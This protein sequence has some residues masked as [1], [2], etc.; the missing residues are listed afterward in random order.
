M[1]RTTA[2]NRLLAFNPTPTFSDSFGYA[3]NY[4][5]L[6]NCDSAT[7]WTKVYDASSTELNTTTFKEG[8][9][10]VQVNY[11]DSTHRA[12]ATKTITAVD[13]SGMTKI[14]FWFYNPAPTSATRIDF[15]VG[16]FGNYREYRYTGEIY[17][18]WTYCEWDIASP[19]ATSGSPNMSAVTYLLV[20]LNYSAGDANTLFVIDDIWAYKSP[21]VT[22][23]V[24]TYPNN[25]HLYGVAGINAAN[26]ALYVGHISREGSG[27]HGRVVYRT[28]TPTNF[29]ASVDIRKICDDDSCGWV[30]FGCD[31]LDGAN[32][33]EAFITTTY[34][35]AGI[36]QIIEG[37]GTYEQIDFT[38][39]T[40]RQYHLDLYVEGQDATF[41]IDGSL[42]ARYTMPTTRTV[43]G[44]V[45]ES[46]AGNYTDNPGKTTTIEFQ[47]F[48]LYSTEGRAAATRSSITQ[49]RTAA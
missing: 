43:G 18:G 28:S 38:F 41:Y 1:A 44:I 49:A 24:W 15:R 30:R 6:D 7:G 25:S 27:N 4:K 9:G 29:H 37:T 19:Y 40:G 14:G 13:I 21:N 26:G 12:A 2:T 39:T 17:T 32:Y 34:S 23:G 48:K 20:I 8:I 22:E 5:K 33:F 35:K 36:S 3:S 47:N 46:S 11:A 16:Q 42:I 45:L 31:F 10:G